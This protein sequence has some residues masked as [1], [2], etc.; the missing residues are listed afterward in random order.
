L[1]DEDGSIIGIVFSSVNAKIL[2]D[3]AEILPQ[4]INYA[5]KAEQ[6]LSLL[7]TISGFQFE[8]GNKGTSNEKKSMCVGLV[9]VEIN[10]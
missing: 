6:L 7:A 5:V 8:K 2:W 1:F 3:A 4:N 10:P 9:R